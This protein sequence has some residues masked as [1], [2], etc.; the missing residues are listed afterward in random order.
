METVVSRDGTPIAFER[1]GSGPPLVL[2]HGT[3]ATLKRWAPIVPALAAQFSV[4][5]I[6]RRGRGES[7]D[8]EPYAIEREFE[9]VA[10]VVDAIDGPVN[11]LGHSYGAVCAL[12]ASLLTDNVG[13]LILYEPPIAVPEGNDEVSPRLVAML[14]RGDRD[15]VVTT[16]MRDVVRMPEQ[17]LEMYRSLPV[18]PERVAIAHTLPRE[19]SA[20]LQYRFEGERFS[21]MT[22]PTL[23]LLGGDSPPMFSD[24]ARLV[25]EALPNSKIEMLPGQ[26]HIAMDTAPEL[27]VESV[28][29]FLEG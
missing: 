1:T 19:Y 9:D 28:R 20:S 24:S 14:D 6:D 21:D 15:G 8:S 18:W 25:D 29:T 2:V 7:G 27:F 13:T 5:A 11:V 22:A 3:T 16:F 26:Q 4:Y 23:I 10:A 12:E 17:D